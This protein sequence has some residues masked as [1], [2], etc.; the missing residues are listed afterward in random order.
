M[1]P[2]L[3]RIRHLRPENADYDVDEADTLYKLGAGAGGRARDIARDILRRRMLDP[4][5]DEKAATAITRV[6]KEYDPAPLDA[7]ALGE[8]AQRAKIPAKKAIARLYLDWNDPVRAEAALSGVPAIDD[9]V[10]LRARAGVAQGRL[11][12]SLAKAEMILAKDRTH[13]DALIVKAQVL[14]AK[15]RARDATNAGT[16]ATATCPQMPA[17][18]IAL[19]SAQEADGNKAGAM[20]AFRDAFDHNDQD[21]ALVRTYTAWLEQQGEGMRAVSI[22]RQLTNN[23][24]SLLSGWRLY[25]ELCARV[26][27]A[28]CGVEA[29]AGLT[30]ARQ[31]FGVDRRS[32][33]PRPTGLF[34]R[35]ARQ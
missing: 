21:S 13:C 32:D 1:V 26:P 16:L 5:L 7:V 28:D 23:A 4:K 2:L 24:P 17:A 20:I 12:E 30:R 27:T 35:L 6:W 22:A 9:V 34:G 25:G 31:H 33:E 14:L 11:D 10:A 29:E 15:R 19:V 3:E 18:Y 8:F